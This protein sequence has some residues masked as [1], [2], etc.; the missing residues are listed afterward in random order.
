[1]LYNRVAGVGWLSGTA[2]ESL[3]AFAAGVFANF[4]DKNIVFYN[5]RKTGH[6]LLSKDLHTHRRVPPF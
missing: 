4:R 2:V 3:R 6:L 1:M 5:C